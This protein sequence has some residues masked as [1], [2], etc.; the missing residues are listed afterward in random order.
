MGTFSLNGLTPSQEISSTVSSQTGAPP[1]ITVENPNNFEINVDYKMEALPLKE[2]IIT[3]N[4]DNRTFD[5]RCSVGD[6]DHIDCMEAQKTLSIERQ[7][8]CPSHEIEL[9]LDYNLD[10]RLGCEITKPS[11][12]FKFIFNILCEYRPHVLAFSQF[13]ND[14]L[15]KLVSQA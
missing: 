3:V 5:D 15:F 14:C 7:E 8:E 13:M 4:N 12:P 10:N 2:L 11:S 9:L 1:N 6:T